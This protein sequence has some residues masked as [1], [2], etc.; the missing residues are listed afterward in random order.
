MKKALFFDGNSIMNRAFYG[1]KP[2][3]TKDGLFTNAVYGYINIVKKHIDEIKPDY[4]GAAFDLK[5]P[6]F[7]HKMYEDYKGKRKPMPEELRMQVEYVHSVTSAM[8]IECLTREGFEADD[9]LG[10][11]SRICA[12]NGIFCTIV[13]GDRDALQL[14]NDNCNVIIAATG[15]D[16]LYTPDT[17]REKYGFDPVHLIDLKALMGD[18]SDNIPGVPGIGEKTAMKLVGEYGDI[19]KLYESIENADVTKS[20]R[21]KLAAGRDSAQMSYKLATIELN[22]PDLP[23]ISELASKG[24]DTHTL[25][26]LFIRLE[27]S[28][29]MK[30]FGIEEE[31]VSDGFQISMDQV[32]VAEEI[33]EPYINISADELLNM[34]GDTLY[35]TYTWAEK[36]FYFDINSTSYRVTDDMPKIIYCDKN[37]VLYNFKDYCRYCASLYG[38]EIIKSI[39]NVVFDALIAAY[40]INP[41]DSASDAAKLIMSFCGKS[42]SSRRA[43]E[44]AY[45]C[46]FLRELYPLLKN[47]IEEYE[48]VELYEK[49]ELPLAKTLAK[50][51]L[52]G[53]KVSR[54]GIIEYGER[55][56][57]EIEAAES[58]IYSYTGAFNINSPKQLGIVLFEKLGLPV[59]KKNKTGYS[60]DAET[61]DRLA[62]R[63]PIIGDI[64]YYRQLTKLYGTYVEGLI[65]VIG[66]DGRIH[67]SFN[68]MLTAT[69]RLSSSEPNLQNIP[70]RTQLGRE[71]RKYFV[72]ENEDYVLVDADYS[73]IELRILAYISKDERLTS[74][75][76]NKE[77]IHSITASQVFGVK[78]ENV[79][80]D[81]RKSAKAV[82]FGIV[83]GISDYSLSIDLGVPKAEAGEY[84]K[85]YFRTY[86]MVKEYL[87]NIKTKAREDGYVTTI[88]NRRRYI[89]ELISPKKQMQAF[90]ERVA[91]NTPIQ[92][93]SAD[94]IKL[95]MV[96][97]D[98]RLEKEGL[99]SRII[100]QV[101]DE[102][103]IEAPK[104]EAEYIKQLLREEMA[105]VVDLGNVKL[106]C[107]A[108]VGDNWHDAH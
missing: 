37:I 99:K 33:K 11:Y 39:K 42:V 8:G 83:Y 48:C 27:F 23:E 56:K 4:I 13:T 63:H 32:Q 7:R 51:E 45:I 24:F 12:E 101:H 52:Y 1:V 15:N 76:A 93:S 67:T 20:V 34:C 26:E 53:F 10:T 17:F 9:I 90:G 103:I 5:A 18:S 98:K 78:L 105:S 29:L 62:S 84:I 92:G 57:T 107:E 40:V 65:K 94:I 25:R 61:L 6:T 50:T 100:M 36:A 81:M 21:E 68:Q 58:R 85:G 74:A 72:A 49:I 75:F 41:T 106:E 46:K 54:E 91:M 64:L 66:D 55:L 71:L 87:E 77:D 89:P 14:V 16:I 96:N 19:E 44:P 102:L 97:V 31:S 60:T 79:T 80:S 3:K 35:L 30:S 73:Q 22:T 95:A 2:L 43:E 88:F 108:A 59:L 28:K 86:P 82:N 70:V 47:K 38:V 69:G 104:S